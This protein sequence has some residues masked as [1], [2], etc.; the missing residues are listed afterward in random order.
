MPDH[1]PAIRKVAQAG[2]KN[3]FAMESL[4]HKFP[5]RLLLALGLAWTLVILAAMGWGVV[6]E[7]QV[8]HDL[9]VAEA[10]ASLGKDMALR[11]WV[12]D[13]SRIYV[14]VGDHIKPQQRMAHLPDRDI[15][16]P[17]GLR[18]TLIDPVTLINDLNRHYG[19]LYGVT[20]KVTSLAAR[21]PH[22]RPDPWEKT[23]LA[24][25]MDGEDEVLQL[26]R[27][28]QPPRLRLMEPLIVQ[29]GC[30]VCHLGEGY[31][32]GK[33]AGGLSVTVSLASLLPRERQAVTSH[34][35]T[36]GALW[37]VGLVGLAIAAWLLRR[38]ARTELA[39]LRRLRAS[40]ARKSAIV[41][42]ALDCIITIDADDH[43]LE[44]NPAAE[45]TFG[46]RADEVIGR[47]LGDLLIPPELR[48]AH[49][50]GLRRQR[51]GRSSKILGT[52]VE[53]HGLRADGTR[54]PLEL[55][56]T[57]LEEDDGVY[58]TAFL[59]DITRPSQLAEE[60]RRQ[61]SQDALTGLLNRRTFEERLRQVLAEGRS[62]SLCLLYLDLDRFKLVNDS[63]GHRAGDELLKQLAQRLESIVDGQGVIGRLGG[64][65]FGVL[66]PEC[67]REAGEVMARRLIDGVTEFRF[68]WKDK[69]FTLGLSVG[70]AHVE[71]GHADASTLLSDADAACYRAK[72][73]GRNRYHFYSPQDPVLHDRR[74]DLGWLHRIQAALAN[75][76][77]ELWYQPIVPLQSQVPA[78]HFVEVLLRMSDGEG[79]LI[80]P[81]RFIPP[82]ERYGLMPSLDRW[83]VQRALAWLEHHAEPELLSINLSGTSLNDAAF[84]EFLV[85]TLTAHPHLAQR[86][87]LEITETEAITSLSRTRA[88][89]E[90]ARR[91]G[92]RFALDDFGSGMASYGYLKDLPVDFL[93]IDGSFVRRLHRD[94]VSR[95][96]V[97]SIHELGRL[98]G[99]Y[100][101]A[102]FV[103]NSSVL[104]ET[105]ALGI[106]YA[107]GFHLGE[108]RPLEEF[109]RETPAEAQPVKMRRN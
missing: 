70:I 15:T 49:R 91:T 27:D 86:L 51:T 17:G 87:C 76:G 29:P 48:E 6:R 52:R 100:T 2:H 28:D 7:R 23:A 67:S 61:A 12:T 34:L 82:A 98:M 59:R 105:E 55:A 102:E 45:A 18:L 72:E 77:F 33:P 94:P 83:V 37:L 22:T 73:E 35:A 90:E 104:E 106:D 43:I 107:Q 85:E 79:G 16:T 42:H 54:F 21:S 50:R 74:T 26:V 81:D 96:M 13:H 24:R 58:F 93:K 9:A 92:C 75:E 88:L 103:V 57:R 64:D 39:A 63:G 101:I 5:A 78:R 89:M 30:L 65:E 14:P 108:P 62:R 53:T 109:F 44:F 46:Y 1:T 8:T 20:G 66:L 40:E 60:L 47:R 71:R 25:L 19:R 36:M 99:K 4:L 69:I 56:I 38:Q 32:V 3:I 80:T 95:A 10:R 68:Y 41:R 31:R 11:R 97:R 84:P